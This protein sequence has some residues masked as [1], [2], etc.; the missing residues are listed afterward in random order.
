MT[1]YTQI[2][3][4]SSLRFRRSST[5]FSPCKLDHKDEK[6]PHN[7]KDGHSRCAWSERG[8]KVPA[9]MSEQWIR[10]LP[11]WDLLCGGACSK[12][13]TIRS[14]TSP[15]EEEELNMRRWITRGNDTQRCHLLPA[16]RFIFNYLRQMFPGLP[17]LRKVAVTKLIHIIIERGFN[18]GE[19]FLTFECHSLPPPAVLW[20][21]TENGYA[22]TAVSGNFHQNASRQQQLQIISLS[23]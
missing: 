15:A 10:T 3:K 13:T 11:L 18:E 21:L 9:W 8:D 23:L 14:D 6:R 5:A 12:R 17:F 16:D 1:Q 20:L 2:V 19:M 4:T 22:V 7:H